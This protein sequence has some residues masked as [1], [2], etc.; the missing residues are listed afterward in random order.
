M[1]SSQFAA[2]HRKDLSTEM[3]RTKIAQRKSLSQKENRHKE[4][5]RNR[6]FGLKDVNIPI[7]EGRSLLEMSETSEELVPKKATMKSSSTTSPV[8]DQRR[9]MLQKFKEEKQLQKLKEQRERAKKGIF[10]VCRFRPDMPYFLSNQKTLKAEPQKDVQSSVRITRSKAREQMEQ[11]KINDGTKVRAT[12]SAPRQTSAKKAL[13]KEKQAPR[14]V[15]TVVRMTRSATNNLQSAKQIVQ[16]VSSATRKTVMSATNAERKSSNEGRSMKKIETKPGEV[17]SSKVESEENTSD[18]QTSATNGIDLSKVENSP[19]INTPK[20]KGKK[21]FAP[22]DFIFQPLNGLRTYQV[23]PMTPRSADAFL[24]PSY[25]WMPTETEVDKIKEETREIFTQECETY[26]TETVHQDSNKSQCLLDSLTVCNKEHKSETLKNSHGH[27]IEV[28]PLQINE[29]QMSQQEH[30]VPY[31]RNILQSERE[32]LITYCLE[33]DKKLQLDIPDD[34]KDLIHLAVGQTRLLMK[35]R[36]KQFEGLVDNCEYKLGEKETTCTDLD[37]F[38]DMINFQI[39]DVKQKF[40]NLTKLEQ[41]GWQNNKTSKKLLRKKVVSSLASQPKQDDSAR[42]AARN[43]LAAIKN[44]MREK[45][46][47]EERAGMANSV[48]PK[49]V[50]KIVFDA[51]FF[52]VE[53]P[54][55]S[56]SG[57]SI[58]SEPLSQKSQTP[59]SASKVVSE[60]R[61]GVDLPRQMTPLAIS[62]PVPFCNERVTTECNLDS[63]RLSCGNPFTPVEKRHQ[64]KSRYVSFG[65]N[66]ITF[67]PLRP[68]TGEQSEE[69]N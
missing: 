4:F 55:K 49:E 5:Q 27:S 63:P 57:L 30:N 64:R 6:L 35:E 37:G 12:L 46:K 66:L 24:T 67:S 38:W 13:D 69:S 42:I 10:K 62:H 32:K 17:I 43:R 15:T 8:C 34:V 40:N 50:D 54:V 61:T 11:I 1:S 59:N 20:M 23:N 3:I 18:P 7:M 33:W 51:G 44:A 2:R 52:R 14:P 29:E 58:S 68:L 39:V 26:S 48:M 60:N 45:I 41:N 56:F 22:K 65:G 25:T 31:F 47:Q 19:K 9:Q 36:F 53:S 28:P 16:T 21:S